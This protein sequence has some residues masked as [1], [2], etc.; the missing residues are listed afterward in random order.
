MKDDIIKSDPESDEKL[1]NED[2]VD[3][4][5]DNDPVVITG[6]GKSSKKRPIII[7]LAL[8]LLLGLGLYQWLAPGGLFNS[9]DNT[10]Q[11]EQSIVIGDTTI[12]QADIDRYA[13]GIDNYKKQRPT[14]VIQGESKQV[15]L[16]DLVMHA[17]LLKEAKENNLSLTDKEIR[18]LY[19]IPSKTSIDD[20]YKYKEANKSTDGVDYY[21][22]VTQENGLLRKKLENKLLQEQ[23]LFYVSVNFDSPFFNSQKDKQKLQKLHDEA[24]AKLQNEILPLFEN[25]ASKE[26]IIDSVDVN[27]IGTTKQDFAKIAD[28]YA[29]QLVVSANE[30]ANYTPSNENIRYV[31]L[32]DLAGANGESQQRSFRDLEVDYGVEVADLKNTNEEISKLQKD[33]DHTVVFASK[34]GTYMI[35]RLEKTGGGEYATWQALLDEYKAKYVPKDFKISLSQGLQQVFAESVKPLKYVSSLFDQQ[36]KAQG[37]SDGCGNHTLAMSVAMIDTNGN[38]VDGSVYIGQLNGTYCPGSPR[39]NGT[40]M[41]STTGN[42]WNG[43]APYYGGTAPAGY[44]IVDRWDGNYTVEGANNTGAYNAYIIVEPTDSRTIRGTSSMVSDDGS[45]FGGGRSDFTH[46]ITYSNIYPDVSNDYGVSGSWQ[47]SGGQNAYTITA[48]APGSFTTNRGTWNLIGDS[49]KS[50]PADASNDWHAQI[51]FRYTLSDDPPQPGNGPTC[52]LS[53]SPVGTLAPNGS[54]TVNVSWSSTNNQEG[55]ITGI[56]ELGRVGE[57][58]SRFGGSKNVDISGPT[59][60]TGT[61]TK[62]DVNPNRSVS[63]SDSTTD[64]P[65]PP[66]PASPKLSPYMRV[67]GNDVIVG[68]VFK[69]ENGECNNSS[70]APNQHIT[71]S[72]ASV[73]ADNGKRLYTGA[74]GQFAVFDYGAVAPAHAETN[75]GIKNFFS[76]N[77]RSKASTETGLNPGQPVPNDLTFGN[78]YSWTAPPV[79]GRKGFEIANG[80]LNSWGGDSGILMCIPNYYNDTKNAGA[81]PVASGRLSQIAESLTEPI[82]DGQRKILVVDG[83]LF[84]DK[85]VKYQ[86][87]RWNSVSDIPNVTVIVKGNIRIDKAVTQLDGIYVAQP[88]NDSASNNPV[89]GGLIYTCADE[90][91][92]YEI[93]DLR[94]TCNKQLVING[95]FISKKVIFHRAKGS[96]RCDEKLP[97]SIACSPAAPNEGASSQNIAEVFNFSPEAYLTPLNSSLETS[98]PYQK[99]DYIT[100]LPPVL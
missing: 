75:G 76:D 4:Q 17:A 70:V 68:S 91:G 67:Y 73:V 35:A 56:G 74:S 54:G 9:N 11:I 80:R 92:P 82:A 41:A 22:G 53:V 33:G 46:S 59:T 95:S 16:D 7:G 2:I 85:D 84:I 71:G 3:Q 79:D 40:G 58:D 29:K 38:G 42:C 50:R 5:V 45:A 36:V 61:W 87:T 100:S 8:L 94:N 65:P 55:S 32:K 24:K 34:T 63:C 90:D 47:V 81:K 23:N 44:R 43:N 98:A 60:F 48:S 1:Q 77:Q 28:M 99:Y 66:P 27:N 19:D 10:A 15:A 12:T 86:N 69:N 14:V 72:T 49:S 51:Q 18:E 37:P 57:A 89:N 26:A 64:N 13:T 93:S 96:V 62:T 39:V 21:E 20:Y 52:T 97:A 6:N 25:D 30:I 88:R 83:D 78:H 31:N